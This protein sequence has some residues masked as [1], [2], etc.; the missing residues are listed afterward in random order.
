MYI[1]YIYDSIPYVY[2]VVILNTQVFKYGLTSCLYQFTRFTVR[3]LL[4]I[5][6]AKTP[7][8]SK[9]L[10]ISPLI[11]WYTTDKLTSNISINTYR[12]GD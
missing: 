6:H 3:Y 11:T 7:C 4:Q 8:D 2:K 5:F 10:N 12:D 1:R 9:K